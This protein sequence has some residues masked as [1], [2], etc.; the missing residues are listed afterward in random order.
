MKK[1]LLFIFALFLWTG[2][3]ADKTV[4]LNTGGSDLWDKSDAK[5]IVNVFTDG[6]SNNTFYAPV[7]RI[8]VSGNYCYKFV[9]SDEFNK[10]VFLR[11]DNS[12]L[13]WEGEWNRIETTFSDNDLFTVTA[14]GNNNFSKTSEYNPYSSSTK[15]TLYL[16]TSFWDAG[17]GDEA[18][19][20]YIYDNTEQT[21][22]WIAPSGN[23]SK[24]GKTYHKFEVPNTYSSVIF[25]RGALANAPINSFDERDNQTQNIDI[26]TVTT[27]TTLYTIANWDDGGKDGRGSATSGYT[28]SMMTLSLLGTASA[29]INDGTAGDAIDGNNGTR[30]GSGVDG[31]VDADWFQV[32][33]TTAQTFNTIRLLCENAMNKGN[34]PE[35]AFDIQTSNNGTDWTTQRAV[36]GKNA[37]N[38]EYITAQFV[39]PVTAMY[40]RFQGVKQGNYG[41]SF[42][43]FELYNYADPLVLSSIN[44]AA[45][46]TNVKTTKTATFTVSGKDQLD[47]VMT[48][49][50]LTWES[51]N[52]SVGEVEEFDGKYIFT[53][54]TVGE[55]T[56]TA[57]GNSGTLSSNPITMTVETLPVPTDVPTPTIDAENVKAVYSHHYTEVG[58]NI[59]GAWTRTNVEFNDKKALKVNNF[60]Y[61]QFTLGATHKAQGME[62]IHLDVFPTENMPTIVIR[63]KGDGFSKEKMKDLTNGTWD[64]D[65]DF[66]LTEDLGLTEEQISNITVI[67]IVK[68]NDG[69]GNGNGTEEFYIGNLY[70]YKEA[71]NPSSITSVSVTAASA[72]IAEGKKTQLTVTDQ[73][74]RNV[75]SLM[76]FVSSDTNVATVDENGLVTAVAAGPATITA[77]VT[78]YSVNSKVD[79]TVTEA[80]L[81][82][83]LTADDRTIHVT[84]Y[85][86]AGTTTYK[87]VI[88]SETETLTGMGGSFWH[89]KGND[90][91]NT[92]MNTEQAMTVNN[93]VITVTGT[94]E[95]APVVYTPLYVMMP[96]QVTYTTGIEN[97]DLDWID[98]QKVTIGPAEWASFSSTNALD[99]GKVEG[100]KAYYATANDGL[101]IS[102]N[103]VEKAPAG[104]GLILGGKQGNYDVPV[105][106]A[107]PALSSTNLLQSTAA[108][109]YTILD[110]DEDKDKVYVFGKIGSDIG[111][112]KGKAGYVI[113]ANKAYL[114]L[115]N[116]LAA[117]GFNFI[118]LP[119]SETD[120]INKVNTL[121]ETGVRYN[122]AGQ[123]V[124]NDYKGIVIVNGRKVVIK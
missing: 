14:E 73:L 46:R 105:I 104:T 50:F 2:A 75:T 79:I 95:S 49:A 25:V 111:F 88:T 20:A 53:A 91:T 71:I 35:L 39:E 110:E 65:V 102:Y 99:F 97:V 42:F 106:D 120:G 60:A 59:E 63:A 93:G 84:P 36:S 7:A 29:S 66:S 114:R 3:W 87:L 72:T 24:N 86:I 89:V 67:Q 68:N 121:V 28:T 56:I 10:A 90:A 51:T 32:E 9:V 11:K 38:N 47:G 64:N 31:R 4:Y 41:Y 13:S 109:A 40:V 85:H 80:E 44:I 77:T 101:N 22:D 94:F 81:G 34:A 100:L 27:N 52:T 70:F 96:G 21:Y 19:G 33:W 23:Q 74:E 98:V 103:T 108:G 48:P 45:N 76:T 6:Q 18:Y 26:S 57:K 69:A 12:N 113:V 117:K 62:R 55:T 58:A 8:S 83:D 17:S 82:F 16:E 115:T 30:W 54:G 112:V 78:G 5:F 61:I 123:R 15:K 37:G 118:G 122:L 1:L 43:E 116:E 124:G 107:A 119:G 92:Q